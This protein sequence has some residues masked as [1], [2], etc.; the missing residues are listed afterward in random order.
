MIFHYLNIRR[1]ID[2]MN[3]LYALAFYPNCNDCGHYVPHPNRKDSMWRCGKFK[4][5]VETCR[6]SPDLCGINGTHFEHVDPL[7]KSRNV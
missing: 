3:F 2:K 7:F 5:F 4:K 1:L 6:E